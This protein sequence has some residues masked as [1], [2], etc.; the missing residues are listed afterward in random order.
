MHQ[1]PDSAWLQ[2][3]RG[4][5][6]DAVT[7][8]RYQVVL[9]LEEG[10]LITFSAP[11]RFAPSACIDSQEWLEFPLRESSM[12]HVLGASIADIHT[13]VENQL[14]IDFSSGDTLVVAWTPMYE[15]YEF[16]ESG[17]RLIV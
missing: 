13:D 16:E 15:C 10:R 12:L 1:P 17:E 11:F 3:F 4:A 5:V 8:C 9:E 14:W 7:F 6:V 2:R